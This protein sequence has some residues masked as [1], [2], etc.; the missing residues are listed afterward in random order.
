MSVLNL[1]KK[2]KEEIK[3]ELEEGIEDETER[4]TQKI[5]DY[6][7]N[8]EEASKIVLPVNLL[9]RL[10]KGGKVEVFI[11][12]DK[13]DFQC[14]SDG[15]TLCHYNLSYTDKSRVIVIFERMLEGE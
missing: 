13:G 4:A 10:E 7:K 9:E 3:K 5:D 2:K 15:E 6:A 14:E 11:L 8:L 12:E 1:L